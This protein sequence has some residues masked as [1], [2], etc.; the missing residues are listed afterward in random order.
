MSNTYENEIRRLTDIYKSTIELKKSGYLEPVQNIMKDPNVVRHIMDKYDMVWKTDDDD[1]DVL[2][3][4]W[5]KLLNKAQSAP[6]IN[7]TVLDAMYTHIVDMTTVRSDRSNEIPVPIVG[8]YGSQEN[9]EP[10][11]MAAEPETAYGNNTISYDETDDGWNSVRRGLRPKRGI[12]VLVAGWYYAGAVEQC[13]GVWN[14]NGVWDLKVTDDY[15][16]PKFT[17]L[18]WRSLPDVPDY[19]MDEVPDNF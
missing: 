11:D 9:E 12:P 2:L 15:G 6:N 8:V 16:K 18:L 3:D 4:I 1:Y 13:I 14:G 5:R 10:A 17:P 7:P 19:I